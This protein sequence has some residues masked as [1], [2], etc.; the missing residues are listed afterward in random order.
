MSFKKHFTTLFLDIGGVLLTNGWDHITRKRAAQHFGLDYDEMNGRHS[1]AFD[2]YETGKMT[3]DEYLN[4]I[5][6][7]YP[8]PFSK[9][10]VKHYMFEQST[11]LPNMLPF[12]LQLKERYRLKVIAVSNEGQELMVHRTQKFHLKELFDCFICSGFVHLRKPDIAIYQLA[13]DI[14]QVNPSEVFYIDDRELLTSV[15]TKMGIH[16]IHHTQFHHTEHQ[17]NQLFQ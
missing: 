12:I 9:E 10:A 17:I 15:A 8:R 11:A 5:I 14:A 6:F 3:L 7:Y 16:S 13:L 1:I 4:E 2:T